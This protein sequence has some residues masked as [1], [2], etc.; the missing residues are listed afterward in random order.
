M[1]GI[2]RE[3]E[4]LLRRAL[5]DVGRWMWDRNLIA[6]TDGNISV[7]LGEGHILSTPSGIPK[8]RMRE[9]DLVV[10]DLQGAVVEGGG[11]PSSEI[12]VHLAA[13]RLR[14]DISAVVHAHPRTA[15]ALTLAG[16]SLAPAIIPETVLTLGIIAAADY[17][18]PGTEDLACK[19]EKSLLR[20][21]AIIM[22]RHGTITLGADPY[23]AYNRLESL[24]HAAQ[25][26]YMARNLGTV[27]PLP[28]NEV[29]HLFQI[30][31][32]SDHPTE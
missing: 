28:E 22:E 7:R 1:S 18:T 4:G 19:M 15:V 30:A 25:I 13:Y 31:A 16:V 6:G 2:D 8:G 14:P 10:T 5:V 26:L 20:H 32:H 11:V 21:D 17:E 12:K 29:E 27:E 9:S 23:H 3:Q 24:E